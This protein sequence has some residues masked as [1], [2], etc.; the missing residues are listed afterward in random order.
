LERLSYLTEEATVT[1]DLLE[2]AFH[3]P[4]DS[5]GS[6][7]DELAIP[8]TDVVPEVG[9]DI[10]DFMLDR[11]PDLAADARSV[12]PN[13]F[14]DTFANVV[15]DVGTDFVGFL[16]S[17]CAGLIQASPDVTLDTGRVGVHVDIRIA[18]AAAR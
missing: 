17:V 9:F 7:A 11:L 13:L 4:G 10:D 15:T 16:V 6:P 3:F 12:L 18:K 14:F 2:G 8:A 5:S 1:D